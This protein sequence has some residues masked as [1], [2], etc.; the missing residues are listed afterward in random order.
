MGT[1]EIKTF[2][3]E[4]TDKI[5]PLNKQAALAQWKAT[6]SGKSEDYAKVEVY[7]KKIEKVF[8]NKNDFKK[9]KEFLNLNV[10]DINTKRQLEVLY[11]S[12]LGSQGDIN[13]L[14]KII[15]KST[16]LEQRFNTF[17]AKI[18]DKE[19][20]DNQIKGIL[21]NETDS[22]KLQT[23]WEASKKQGQVVE[24]DLIKLIELRN[25][26]ARSLGFKN[27]Y[28]LSL[29]LSDQT[30]EGVTKLF[31]ELDNL[32]RDSYKEVK[33]EIDSF[34]KERFK[35][36]ELKP[37]HYQDLFFQEAPKINDVNL[38]KYY[39]DDI[40][41]KA[42]KFYLSIGL[43]D[44]SKI[45][46]N[47]DLYEKKGKYQH[48]YCM[49]MDREGDVRSLMNIKNN[50]YW[51]GT[52]LHE[53][54]HGVYWPNIDKNLP[55]FIRECSHTL[56][57]EAIAQLFERNSQNI[58]FIKEFSNVPIENAKETSKLIQKDLRMRELVFSRWSQVMFNFERNLYDNPD[59]NLN[60][61][62][63]SLVNKYQLVDFSRDEPDWASKIH[64]VSA[65]VYYHN[66]L[67]G[68]LYSSQINNYI[69][70]NILHKKSL[71]NLKYSGKKEIGDY[72]KEKIFAP[73]AI[74]KWD[75]LV[76]YSTGEK[77]NPAYWTK[78]FA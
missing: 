63:W 47:S 68:E 16:A 10:D 27:Y 25:E 71:K 20:S 41:K 24:K 45:I 46:K 70:K 3:E 61:L 36:N 58:S 74:Y 1:K 69:A 8:N 32:T 37:W 60:K 64:F 30:E 7:S 66:Y 17:R 56:T 9:V 52:V 13:L 77:L 54:G 49:D 44:V 39:N 78:E 22:S 26:H 65:P 43:K 50:E 18:D 2:L 48:A 6:I 11:D 40:L 72:L 5:K 42:E 59:Q 28:T 53:L 57:T 15:E 14:N 35:V 75:E 62:W 23:A 55:Y 34:L 4:K 67:I 12:Y 31:D 21:Q 19:F 38:D 33:N 73:G 76:E 51:M 29:K